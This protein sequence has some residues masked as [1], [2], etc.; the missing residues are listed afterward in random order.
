LPA[1]LADDPTVADTDKTL[2]TGNVNVHCRA[3]GSLPAGDV[4]FRFRETAPF[5][6]AVPEARVRESVCANA[7][8]VASKKNSAISGPVL[9][10]G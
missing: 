5:A 6:A 4:K 1:L 10:F 7:A 9:F 3:A 8:C 2:L